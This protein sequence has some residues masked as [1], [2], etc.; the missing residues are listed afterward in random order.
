MNMDI[1]SRINWMPGMELTT[2]TFTSLSEELDFRQQMALRAALGSY[3]MGLLPG[4]PFLNTG[5]F[6][7]NKFEMERFRCL[8]VLPSGRLLDVDESVS[9]A[10]PM[11][12][13]DTYYLAVS[14]GQSHVEFEKEGIPYVRP[15]YEY[16][17][18]TLEEVGNGDC[19]PVVRFRVN[20]G[21]FSIDPDFI[22]PCLLLSENPSFQNYTNHYIDRLQALVSHPNL[23]EGEGKRA[24]LRYL[25]RLKGYGLQNSL[26]DY[27]LLLQEV[28]QAVD[29]YIATPHLEEP[30]TIPQP[31]LCDVQQ[32][33]GWAD[34]YLGGAVS[35]LDTVVLVDNTIDYEAL[36]AQAKKELYE[37]LNPELYEKLLKQIKEELNEE[38]GQR[39]TLTLTAYI[40][41]TL[42]PTLKEVLGK[43]LYDELYDKLYR[44]LYDRLYNTLY[45]PSAEEDEF[46]PMI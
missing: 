21:V 24:L 38:L 34:N 15:Q 37:Q 9:V 44:D 28:V 14:L 4:A 46:M 13:G 23:E 20:N 45:V 40:D 12:Y 7:K 10:I 32:W 29:Y 1:N 36:L 30:P 31:N 16:S 18:A 27:L 43:E 5:L 8:A 42:K 11:L 33:M 26:Q 22:P 35:I 3:R 6:A 39:L 41:E 17:I 25:F 19:L 2:Q